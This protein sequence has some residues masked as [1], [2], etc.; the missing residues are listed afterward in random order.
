MNETRSTCPYCGVGCGVVI[1]SEGTQITDAGGAPIGLVTS[2]GFGPSLN[3]P[4]AMGYVT[5]GHAAVGTP[6]QLLV[7]GKPMPARVVTLPFV[8]HR[9]HRG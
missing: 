1:E 4:L 8:P 3:G 6:L 9:F 5:A 2:G 7:R